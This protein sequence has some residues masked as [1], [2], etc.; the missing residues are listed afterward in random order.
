MPT[1]LNKNKDEKNVDWVVNP[2]TKTENCCCKKLA[3]SIN[4]DEYVALVKF[5]W[6][7]FAQ[8]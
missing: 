7:I 5:V 1:A 3:S 6:K 4:S 2:F 8:C